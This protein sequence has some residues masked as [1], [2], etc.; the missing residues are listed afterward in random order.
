MARLLALIIAAAWYFCLPGGFV[1]AKDN[2]GKFAE[3]GT[4]LAQTDNQ[5]HPTMAPGLTTIRPMIPAAS[6]VLARFRQLKRWS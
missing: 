3:A 1:A 2:H 5:Q 6:P 4:I